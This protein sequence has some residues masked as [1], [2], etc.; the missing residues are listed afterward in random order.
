VAAGRERAP[1]GALTLGAARLATWALAA[2]GLLAAAAFGLGLYRSADLPRIACEQRVMCEGLPDY[3]ALAAEL[4]A[5][6]RVLVIVD[7]GEE[8]AAERFVC[9]RLALAPRRVDARPTNEP[10]PAPGEADVLLRDLG[11]GATLE[12]AP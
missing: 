5:T 9:A 3:A 10:P 7:A 12:V 11:R 1:G 6:A 2:L 8:R 4:P